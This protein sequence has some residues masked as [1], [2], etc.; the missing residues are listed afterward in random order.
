MTKHLHFNEELTDDDVLAYYQAAG[1]TCTESGTNDEG[2][3]IYTIVNAED[4][5]TINYSE[6]RGIATKL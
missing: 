2:G 1:Y 6:G 4:G 3:K 5:V